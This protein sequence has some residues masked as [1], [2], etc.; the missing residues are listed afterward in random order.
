M[1]RW[2]TADGVLAEVGG[3]GF[4]LLDA[5]GQLAREFTP[6]I[7]SV[8]DSLYTTI[9]AV[10]GDALVQRLAV[11]TDAL[12]RNEDRVELEGL[13]EL[14]P[15]QPP[16][17]ADV[18]A[19]LAARD[20]RAGKAEER[21]RERI[22]ALARS[23]SDALPELSSARQALAARVV[24][25][26]DD[27][28]KALLHCLSELAEL[29]DE[30]EGRPD[31]LPWVAAAAEELA[32]AAR[33]ITFSANPEDR[34]LRLHPHRFGP[35]PTPPASPVLE[36]LVEPLAWLEGTD[37]GELLERLE[38]LQR[39]VIFRAD[40]QAY[41]DAKETKA[42]YLRAATRVANAAPPLA[43]ACLRAAERR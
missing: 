39:D 17:E 43:A 27:L 26:S 41:F 36:A 23:P 35:T 40:M 28:A 13:R 34:A 21:T 33:L 38:E 29:H 2:A 11:D 18:R 37:H 32:G 4:V 7:D 14:G 6:R 31:A 16:T 20:A 9:Y 8:E 15:E 42:A 1:K 19:A 5:E 25:Y 24:R 12:S 3:D 10:V 22:A 30:L